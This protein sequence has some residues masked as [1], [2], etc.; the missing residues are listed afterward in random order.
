MVVGVPGEDVR[1]ARDAGA[2]QLFR[3]STPTLAPGTLLT[4]DTPGVG[5]PVG[6]QL[7]FA[8][9]GLGDRA[10]RLAVAVPAEDAAAINQGIVHVFPVTDLD[11]ET[12]YAQDSPGV[13]GAAAAGDEFGE[14]L[15][16]VTGFSERRCWSASPTTWAT[17]PAW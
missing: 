8:A 16:F 10:T 12:T 15:A 1:R 17:G 9:P 7:A 5:R 4:Q 6:S 2:V 14:T 13:P 3:S 11:A